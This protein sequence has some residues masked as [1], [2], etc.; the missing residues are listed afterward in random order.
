MKEVNFQITKISYCCVQEFFLSYKPSHECFPSP[1][2]VIICVTGLVFA[3]KST[4]NHS[5][6]YADVQADSQKLAYIY[7]NLTFL[8]I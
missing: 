5:S 4:T 3:Y 8:H 7:L 1:L 2:K 6:N